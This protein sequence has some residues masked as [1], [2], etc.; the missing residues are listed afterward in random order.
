MRFEHKCP[1]Y[2]MKK[3]DETF[4]EFMGCECFEDEDAKKFVAMHKRYYEG[5]QRL[6]PLAR[7]K[8]CK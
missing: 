1:A 2:K 5:I 7:F 3:I 8:G 6:S 4:H